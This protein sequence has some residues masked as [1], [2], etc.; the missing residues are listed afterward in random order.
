MGFIAQDV[1]GVLP[2]LVVGDEK[3]DMLTVDYAHLSVVAIGA[4]QEMHRELKAENE[5]LRAELLN[6][7]ARRSEDAGEKQREIDA[8]KARLE[9]L[10]SMVVSKGPAIK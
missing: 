9:R 8:L 1:K 5:A 4:L 7:T 6:Q 2:G 3:K 10:E